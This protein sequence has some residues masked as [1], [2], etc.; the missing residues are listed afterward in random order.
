L[1]VHKFQKKIFSKYFNRIRKLLLEK[2]YSIKNRLF[3]TANNNR[4]TK[5][6][7]KFSYKSTTWYLGFHVSCENCSTSCAVVMSRYRKFCHMCK[8]YQQKLNTPSPSRYIKNDFS[9]MKTVTS[10]HLGFSYKKEIK[11]RPNDS[12]VI[13]Y[14]DFEN[15]RDL[16][17]L[18]KPSDVKYLNRYYRKW[19]ELQVQTFIEKKSLVRPSEYKKVLDIYKC[20]DLVRQ[21]KNVFNKKLIK[22]VLN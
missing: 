22:Q 16:D 3:Q 18:K 11:K 15:S 6:F 14:R 2:Y 21:R 4:E 17:N 1:L 20:Y 7:I 12:Y 9:G 10:H 5:T 19:S 13:V 8:V